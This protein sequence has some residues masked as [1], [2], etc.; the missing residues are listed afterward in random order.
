MSAPASIPLGLGTVKIGRNQGVKYP[1]AFDLPDDRSVEALLDLALALGITLLDTA[2]AYGTSEERLGKLLGQRREQFSIL[3]KA[4]E[5]FA[6]GES[7]FD[8]SGDAISGSI[9]RSLRRLHTDRVDTVL[10]HSDGND[11]AILDQSG[12]V[13]ALFAA[14]DKG[15]CRQI[16]I[17]TKTVAGGLRAIEL[18]LDAVMITYHPDYLEEEAVLDEAAKTGTQVYLKKVLGSGWTPTR[19]E[20]ADPIESAFRFVRAHPCQPVPIVGTINPV[21]LRENVAAFRKS[22]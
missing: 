21:H 11:L 20:D 5:D 1:K 18:G 13:D 7:H 9:E 4:G 17:S 16:G 15:H 6:N 3:T 12:A 10:L 19:S 14:R 8:F 22:L 2:P